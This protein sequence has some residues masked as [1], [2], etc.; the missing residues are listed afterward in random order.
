MNR[1]TGLAAGLLAVLLLV[2]ANISVKD[3]RGPVPAEP[4][5]S[6]APS[7]AKAAAHG[8]PQVYSP[9]VEIA[10]RLRRLI[11]PADK[12]VESWKLPPSCYQSDSQGHETAKLLPG[13]HIAIAI[14]PNPISTHLPLMFDRVVESIQQGAQDDNYSYDASWFPWDAA[15]KS[16]E[17]LGDQQ[18][19]EDLQDIQQRQPGVIVFRQS[20]PNVLAK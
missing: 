4:R 18:A 1:N 9:C 3:S 12:P 7:T 19:A 11:T 16:Y 17:L 10:K 5:N 6:P 14:A 20:L 2:G 8:S 13:V 15:E